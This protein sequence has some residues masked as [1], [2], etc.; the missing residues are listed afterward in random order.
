MEESSRDPIPSR[1]IPPGGYLPRISYKG[2]VDPQAPEPSRPSEPSR[3]PSKE[4]EKKRT[5]SSESENPKKVLKEDTPEFDTFQ[6]RQ[7]TR[8]IVGGVGLALLFLVGYVVFRAL[9]VV[10]PEEDL[11]LEPAMVAGNTP[12]QQ[13]AVRE[14][15]ARQLL[16]DAKLY[17]KRGKTEQALKRLEQL[18]TAY[19]GSNAAKE[20][21]AA[22]ER[23]R[24]RLPLFPEGPVVVA[25]PAEAPPEL[26][27]QPK[28]VVVMPNP[29]V[30]PEPKT[31]VLAPPPTPP[32][33]R[34]E[35]GLTF[36]TANVVARP[37]PP[38][39]RARAE[40][41]IHTSGWP[42][43]ITC[44]RDGSSMVLVPGAT[45]SMGNNQGPPSERP[46]HPVTLSTYY[47]DQHE[48]TNR[49]FQLYRQAKPAREEAT[50][51]KNPS[52]VG[53]SLD[54]ERPAVNVSLD[55]ARGYAEWAGKTIPTE[56]QW[57]MAARSPDGRLHPWGRGIPTWERPREPR[58]I[59]RVMSF[60][61][62]LSPYGVYD[63]A[64]N[65]WEWTND[66][67][68]TRSFQQSTSTPLL[69][70]TGPAR[71][72]ARIPEVT[73]K[74]GSTDWQTSWRSGM[75][76]SARLP[77][78]GFRGVLQVEATPVAAPVSPGQ[79]VPSPNLSP[80]DPNAPVPF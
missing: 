9:S 58:Q 19:A 63:L 36:E 31:A 21:K 11:G 56:A 28:Y 66:W 43:E 65:A 60:S 1:P 50:D 15:Q 64:G 7:R 44:D 24:Q 46:A 34:H 17:E 48:V 16:E 75:R 47:I 10:E 33:P 53:D 30:S 52:G 6:A 23:F 70:P 51:E 42:L 71:S 32:E 20:G 45:F 13:A 77:Y 2:P 27:T 41:G 69:N 26:P 37:L 40:A 18:Q 68:D 73:V 22:L 14:T 61:A 12:A 39:F 80:R 57:E 55:D 67:F 74:G 79:P 4:K 5:Y 49:Q 8:W 35:T 25:K 59:D 78:L 29:V 54:P 3:P 38:G 62:D 72:R 76:P